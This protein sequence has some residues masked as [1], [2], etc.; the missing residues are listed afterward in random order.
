MIEDRVLQWITFQG[1]QFNDQGLM[2]SLFL[3]RTNGCHACF[4]IADDRLLEAVMAIMSAKES[5]DIADG[6]LQQVFLACFHQD[7]QVQQATERMHLNMLFNA[8]FIQQK[9][10]PS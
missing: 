2:C 3:D 5:L 9:L 6:V 4:H 7:Q 1:S 8:A 10:A